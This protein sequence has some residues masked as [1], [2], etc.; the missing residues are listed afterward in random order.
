MRYL[1]VEEVL[2]MHAEVINQTGGSHGVRDVLLLDG[3][4]EKPKMGFGGKSL[5]V[6]VYIKAAVYLHGFAMRHVFIDG[7]KR[8]AMIAAARC[9]SINGWALIATNKEF[10]DFA[11]RVVVEKL[12]IE[13]IAWWPEEHAKRKMKAK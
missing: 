13:A 11:V 3:I 10:E 8:T 6:G 7:N 1:V 12:E 2:V 5:Y 4:V 9:L